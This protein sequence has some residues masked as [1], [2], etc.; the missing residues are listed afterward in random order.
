[1]EAQ[2]AAY[3]LLRTGFCLP[4]E[5]NVSTAP[6]GPSRYGENETPRAPAPPPVPHAALPPAPARRTAAA[7]P[8]DLRLVEAWRVGLLTD[9]EGLAVVYV[10]LS[11]L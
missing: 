3:S 7:R 2:H 4:T 10:M 1:M 9:D 5:R 8:P 11:M 6:C